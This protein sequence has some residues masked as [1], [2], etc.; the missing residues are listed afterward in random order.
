MNNNTPSNQLRIVFMGTPE[1]AAHVLESLIEAGKNIAGVV[2]VPDKP[3]GRGQKLTLSAVKQTALEHNIKVLQP[4][5][6]KDPAFIDELK[7]LQPDLQIVVAFRMLPQAVWGLPPKGSFNLHA[8][9]LPQYRGAAPINHAII[10]GEKKTG[11][12]TF[13]LDENI[14]TGNIIFSDTVTID[15]DETAGTLH[16]KLMNV[17]A[18]LVI[19]T[20]DAIACG[21]VTPTPQPVVAASELKGAPKIFKEDCR[22]NWNMDAETIIN[23][24]KGLSPYPAAFTELVDL[25]GNVT[26]MKIFFARL[27]ET[28]GLHAGETFSDNKKSVK[29]G[30][31][32]ND[33]ELTDIQLAAKK[34]MN[35]EDFLR[36]F[37]WGIGIGLK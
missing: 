30:S 6:L 3:A 11:V 31:L 29:V 32:T 18:H 14:D 22:I 16:D 2:T 25:D 8:S 9:L 21:T 5:K 33:I 28:S 13:F 34:R 20:A 37:K 23:K 15:D 36:G 4:V 35:I 1:F 7:A 27:A 10:N 12:T 26:A 17:G 24:I 19:E